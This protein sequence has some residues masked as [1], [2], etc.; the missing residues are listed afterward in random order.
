MHG[1]WSSG[2]ENVKFSCSV[3]PPLQPHRRRAYV[4]KTPGKGTHLYR[5]MRMLV[6]IKVHS[7]TKRLEIRLEKLPQR[8]PRCLRVTEVGVQGEEC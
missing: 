3:P 2:T 4:V 5:L 6:F 8:K 7:L 1:R